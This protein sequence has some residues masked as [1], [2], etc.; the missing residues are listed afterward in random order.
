MSAV[1][2]G[3]EEA[4]REPGVGHGTVVVLVVVVLLGLGVVVMVIVVVG[5]PEAIP[6]GGGVMDE[7]RRGWGVTAEGRTEVEGTHWQLHSKF[8]KY[9]SQGSSKTAAQILFSRL[10][11]WRC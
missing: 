1:G 3:G 7:V 4:V 9:L 10:R 5:S 6:A 2:G 11:I 8:Y